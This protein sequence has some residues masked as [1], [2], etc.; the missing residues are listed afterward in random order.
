MADNCHHVFDRAA[1]QVW[2]VYQFNHGQHSWIAKRTDRS[3]ADNED[4][5]EASDSE[6]VTQVYRSPENIRKDP[7]NKLTETQTSRLK[8]SRLKI[9]YFDHFTYIFFKCIYFQS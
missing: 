3:S 1:G 4:N 6:L 8:D 9:L 2:N 5:R 7:R